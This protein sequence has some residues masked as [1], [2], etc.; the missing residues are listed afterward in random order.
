MG[1]SLVET[2]RHPVDVWLLTIPFERRAVLQVGA[3]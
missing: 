1:F 3:G 2:G